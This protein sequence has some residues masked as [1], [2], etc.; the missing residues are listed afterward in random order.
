MSTTEHAATASGRASVVPQPGGPID[1][2]LARYETTAEQLRSAAQVVIGKAAPAAGERVVDLGCGTGNAALI[3]AACRAKVTGVDPA[4]RLLE[5]ARLRAAEA[6]LDVTF[7]PGKA[8]AIPLP[9]DAADVLVSVFAVIFASDPEAAAAEMA[10]V[11]APSGRI[12]LSAWVPWGPMFEFSRESGETVRRALGMPARPAPFA[13]H[14]LDTLSGLLAPHGFT[15]TLE[16][17]HLV[18]TAPSPA[19]FVDEGFDNHPVA[20]SSRAVLEPRGEL[21]ALRARLLAVLDAANEDPHAFRITAPY[22]VAT[23]RRG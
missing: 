16:D 1:W 21:P 4:P 7:T 3:A 9:D 15:V 11:T 5:V 20:F 23:A 13:W 17:K 10:R 14:D 18:H 6:G 22:V 8:E 19:A 12:V 2:G